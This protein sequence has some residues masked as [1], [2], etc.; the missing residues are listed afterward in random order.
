MIAIYADGSCSGNP[1]PGGF[2]AVITV[3]PSS[4]VTVSG[5]TRATTN[6]RMELM[7]VVTGLHNVP[8]DEIIVVTDSQYVVES[9]NSGWKRRSNKDLW[10]LLDTELQT[11]TNV[12]FQ[13]VKGHSGNALNEQAN[14]RAQEETQLAIQELQKGDGLCSLETSQNKCDS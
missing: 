2:A 13:W 4:V 10:K 3:D 1:G 8:N 5:H 9:V 11:H 7:A 6:Q 12:R 14:K